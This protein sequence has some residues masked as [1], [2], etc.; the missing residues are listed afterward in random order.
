MRELEKKY[1]LLRQVGSGGFSQVFKVRCLKENEIYAL[2]VLT[3]SEPTNGNKVNLNS[4]EFDDLRR[5]VEILKKI[6]SNNIVKVYQEEILD[7][8]LC[9]K[10]E[11][12][13]GE[14]LEEILIKE[15]SLDKDTVMDIILQISAALMHCHNFQFKKKDIGYKTET[16]ILRETAIIHNDIHPK[17][18]IRRT[19]SDGE[20][21]YVLIDFG[22]SFQNSVA[23]P[24][25]L[26]QHGFA[27]YKSPEKWLEKRLMPSSD[28]YSFGILIYRCLAGKVPFEVDG[29]LT[30]SVLEVLKNRHLTEVPAPIWETRKQNLEL[31]KG[32][33][34]T[35]PDYPYWLQL[36][37][38]KS[39][40]KEPKNRFLSGRELNNYFHDGKKGKLPV[41]W[42]VVVP[43]VIPD[44]YPKPVP[45]PDPTP[46][47]VPIIN[48]VLHWMRNNLRYIKLLFVIL[49][50]SLLLWKGKD[51]IPPKQTS[52]L[53][54]VEE[55]LKIDKGI[56]NKEDISSLIPHLTFPLYYY[57]KEISTPESFIDNY[58]SFLGEDKRR[59]IQIDSIVPVNGTDSLFNVYG[60]MKVSSINSR[61]YWITRTSTI[62]DLIEL[63]DGKIKK[64]EKLLP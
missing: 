36:I 29:S 12:V 26:N 25:Q 44:L 42:P 51:F 7:G 56:K 6:D 64:F 52:P 41:N 31:R 59:E 23:M 15:K 45:K 8:K 13:E 20:Y 16:T 57:T 33:I 48:K 14:T 19:L 40:E 63:K 58:A 61:G 27:E 53:Q 17:N 34:A 1:D 39:L 47:P 37:V 21:E 32:I 4:S 38:E 3:L 5:E 54:V 35:Q 9:I 2:K 49:A 18:I 46:Q 60:E 11:F 28:I 50:V 22:L 30:E 43:E 24:A 62:K 55:Y 10:M